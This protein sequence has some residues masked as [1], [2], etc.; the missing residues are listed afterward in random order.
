VGNSNEIVK[1]TEGGEICEASVDGRGF[2]KVAPHVLAKRIEDMAS[3]PDKLEALGKKGL[4][5]SK[6]KFNWNLISKEYEKLFFELINDS[7]VETNKG[8]NDE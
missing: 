2:T 7:V 1:W 3:S 5:M 6:A 8:F 4:E